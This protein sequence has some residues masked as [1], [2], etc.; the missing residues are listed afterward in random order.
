MKTLL[1]LFNICLFPK[2]ELRCIRL[3]QS[4][5]KFKILK[6]EC[7]FF[8]CAKYCCFFSYRWL[9]EKEKILNELW[10]RFSLFVMNKKKKNRFYWLLHDA[11]RIVSATNCISIFSF[12]N[13]NFCPNVFFLII[14]Y[15]EKIYLENNP[16][17][18]EVSGF[19]SH[20]AF[21]TTWCAIK[22][23]SKE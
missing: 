16:N 17:L 19:K 9:R 2:T 12:I 4:V 7:R 21:V 3:S 1:K 15:T 22:I 6:W 13:F 11:S 8:F 18:K 5:Y 14:F 10:P 23:W 20:Y